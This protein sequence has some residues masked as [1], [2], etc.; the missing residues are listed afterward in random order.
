MVFKLYG[1][2]RISAASGPRCLFGGR[3]LLTFFVANAALIRGR[4]LFGVALIRVNTV[5]HAKT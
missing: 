5:N 2:P 3:R 1:I 4:R